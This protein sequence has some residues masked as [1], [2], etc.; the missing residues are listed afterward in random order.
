MLR[1]SLCVSER[2]RFKAKLDRLQ[3]AVEVPTRWNLRCA[4]ERPVAIQRTI[5]GVWSSTSRSTPGG[6][7]TSQGA[8]A[9]APRGPPHQAATSVSEP[10]RAAPAARLPQ[11][12]EAGA[13][14]AQ[15]GDQRLALVG[16][17]R[18]LHGGRW[19]RTPR[20]NDLAK[21]YPPRGRA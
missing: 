9:S 16:L 21:G 15:A 5:I 12:G 17:E 14:A 10:G 11:E 2:L 4:S 7:G 8:G 19:Y 3:K 13:G 6:R 1:D 20:R 18:R